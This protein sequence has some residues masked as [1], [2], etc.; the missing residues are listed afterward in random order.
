MC[1]LNYCVSMPQREGAEKRQNERKPERPL[2]LSRW[3]A[4][5]FKAYFIP[6]WGPQEDNKDLLK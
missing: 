4:L 5:L 1:R 3:S 6:L 2:H